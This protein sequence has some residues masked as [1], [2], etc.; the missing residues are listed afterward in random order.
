[1]EAGGADD[2]PQVL[3]VGASNAAK[4]AEALERA[5]ADVL[6]AILP[7]W[8]CLKM[9][10]PAMVELVKKQLEGASP[11]RVAVF[12]LYD[13]SFH[14][15]RTE[16]GSLIPACRSLADGKFHTQGEAVVA[17]KESQFSAFTATKAVIEAAGKLQKI[18]ISPLPR[19]L[20]N[21]CCQDPDHC[22]N[23]GTTGYREET[24]T[25]ILACRSN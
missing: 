1:M 9:K 24:E 13:S 5:G 22:T 2:R 12:Q 25:A 17:P 21:S 19:H 6:R 20:F 10:V 7:G 14:F 18:I 4:T 8:R 16:L 23:I 11:R 3:V 15:A